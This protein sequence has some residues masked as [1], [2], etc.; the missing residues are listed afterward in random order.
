LYQN[1]S[2]KPYGNVNFNL[3]SN[4]TEFDFDQALESGL[5]G[6]TFNIISAYLAGTSQII[7]STGKTIL[8]NQRYVYYALSGY[9]GFAGEAFVQSTVYELNKLNEW[10]DKNKDKIKKYI[11]Y[12]V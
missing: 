9:I 6:G 11:P 5:L 10:F 4:G 3:N 2:Y 12:I 7:S 8:D 1:R